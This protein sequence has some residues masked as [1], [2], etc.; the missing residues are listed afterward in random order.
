VTDDSYASGQTEKTVWVDDVVVST[1][2]IGCGADPADAGARPS[3]GGAPSSGSGG[4]TT[5]SGGTSSGGSSSGGTTAGSG[6]AATSGG[7]PGTLGIDGGSAEP[8]S[9][10]SDDGGCGCGCRM[11]GPRYNA[12]AIVLL[13][14][15]SVLAGRRRHGRTPAAKRP[16]RHA[17]G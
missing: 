4:A 5:T 13:V 2:P 12:R 11:A 3:A 1:A 10:S 6:S 8:V 9:S 7:S 14:G 17:G 16:A 15:L